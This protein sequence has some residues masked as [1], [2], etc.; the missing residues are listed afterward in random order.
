MTQNEIKEIRKIIKYISKDIQDTFGQKIAKLYQKDLDT[1]L[2]II[3]K[4]EI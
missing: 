1:I 3:E 4:Y 2:R